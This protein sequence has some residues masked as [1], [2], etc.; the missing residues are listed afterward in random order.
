MRLIGFTEELPRAETVLK[1]RNQFSPAWKPFQ[2][3]LGLIRL[4]Q[5]DTMCAHPVVR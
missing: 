5:S 4:L 1:A 3:R 2:T